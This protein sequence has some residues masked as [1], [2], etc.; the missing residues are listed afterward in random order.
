MLYLNIINRRLFKLLEINKIAKSANLEKALDTI[1]P[2]IFWK[3]KPSLKI[4][5]KKW[6]ID[7]I[8]NLLRQTYDLELKIKSNSFINHQ[9]LIKKL[10]IDICAVA[11]A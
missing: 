1:K 8:K 11:N 3:D 9:V 5:L 6:N 10:M 7:K 4:Q 2:P